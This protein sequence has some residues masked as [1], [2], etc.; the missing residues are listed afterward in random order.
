M[1]I[2]LYARVSKALDQKPENQ[3]Q[4]L[5]D[6]IAAAKHEQVKDQTNA[7]N[8]I[9][10]DTTSSKDLRPK[11]EE[12]LKLIRLGV[13]DGVAFVALDRWGRTMSELILELEEFSKDGKAIIS[14]KEGLDLS[15]AA[16]RFMANILASFA[17][18]ERDKIKER[19]MMGL[20]R[21]RNTGRI[22]GRHP[23]NCGC[24]NMGKDGKRHNGWVKPVRDLHNKITGWNFNKPEPVN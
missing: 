24:G 23:V 2:C 5:L 21:A 13:A 15:S 16:G 1:R 12:V 9:F 22:L 6:W 11:K 3:Y 4:P 17:N 10:I 19:T 14:L 7:I 20:V 8:G 18:F